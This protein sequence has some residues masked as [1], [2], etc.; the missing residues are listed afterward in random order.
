MM[1]TG[2]NKLHL[3]RENKSITG[4]KVIKKKKKKNVIE[5]HGNSYS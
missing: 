4:Q 5:D 2:E 3:E 1:I